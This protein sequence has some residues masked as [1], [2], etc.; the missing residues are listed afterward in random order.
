[1][2]CFSLIAMINCSCRS[3]SYYISSFNF[4]YTYITIRIIFYDT[5]CFCGIY[6]RGQKCHYKK[7]TANYFFHLWYIWI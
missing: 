1:M 6:L 5:F 3:Y 4:F 7:N 2:F